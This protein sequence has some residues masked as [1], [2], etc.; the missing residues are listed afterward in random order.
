MT[1]CGAKTTKV[2][3]HRDLGHDGM[4]WGLL[5]LDEERFADI[6]WSDEWHVEE[7]LPWV[8]E[9]NM[10]CETPI[11][12]VVVFSRGETTSKMSDWTNT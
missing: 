2:E 12:P 10:V 7:A 9:T 6:I 1:R 8:V 11:F 3:C 5:P 4:H